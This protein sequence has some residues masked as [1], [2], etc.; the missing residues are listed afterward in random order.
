MSHFLLKNKKDKI[1]FL[2]F[3]KQ[4][5]TFYIWKYLLI[6]LLY[7]RIDCTFS[8]QFISMSVPALDKSEI[9]PD[10]RRVSAWRANFGFP[11]SIICTLQP[12]GRPKMQSKKFSGLNFRVK[13]TKLKI[14]EEVLSRRVIWV[15]RRQKK[16][17]WFLSNSNL[18][19]S[20]S[21]SPDICREVLCR[22]WDKLRN[23]LRHFV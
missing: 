5:S 20:K 2:N 23:R 21:R 15:F 22:I 1:S 9:E 4:F 7:R 13:K 12:C 3:Q 10:F 6:K 19:F 8:S 16:F 11:R 18:K 14:T 17:W